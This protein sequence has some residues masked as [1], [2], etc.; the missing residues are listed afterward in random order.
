MACYVPTRRQTLAWG[1]MKSM[2]FRWLFPQCHLC[3]GKRVL[4]SSCSS[5]C[6]MF[7]C[8]LPFKVL[9]TKLLSFT[10]HGKNCEPLRCQ[11]LANGVWTENL[12]TFA[13]F[14][15]NRPRVNSQ[16]RHLERSY[17]GWSN[18]Q[19]SLLNCLYTGCDL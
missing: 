9:A 14:R 4:Q 16:A 18:V 15:Q 17:S 13:N 19:Q 12:N 1:N 5:L 7:T 10:S 8:N 3:H 11:V 6:G 2:L